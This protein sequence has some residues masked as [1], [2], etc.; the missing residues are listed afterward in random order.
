[1]K[2]RYDLMGGG[3]VAFGWLSSAVLFSLS[4]SSFLSEGYVT[5]ET[6]GFLLL[7]PLTLGLALAPTR[8]EGSD[9]DR[10]ASDYWDGDDVENEGVA[11]V[12]DSDFDSP[13]L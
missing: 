5:T 10:G 1:M 9:N 8:E 3:R 6:W 13:I 2:C 7:T 12:D 4:I 11:S